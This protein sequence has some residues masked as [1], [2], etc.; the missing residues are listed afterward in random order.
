M[1]GCTERVIWKLITICKIDSQWEFAIR[2]RELKPMLYDNLEGWDEMEDGREDREG[3]DMYSSSSS[4]GH[5][6][7]SD[8]LRPCRL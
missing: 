5:L 7:M 6:V 4:V 1:V 3:S 8:C 2:C